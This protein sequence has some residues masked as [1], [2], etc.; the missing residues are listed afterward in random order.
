M[1]TDKDCNCPEN[2]DNIQVNEVESIES[3][4][5]ALD[6]NLEVVGEDFD[7]PME[8]PPFQDEFQ[9]NSEAF[10]AGV[11]HDTKKVTGLWSKDETRNS[12]AAING[13]GW[14]KLNNTNNSSCVALTILSAHAKQY[15]KNVKLNIDNNQIKEMY[16]W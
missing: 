2:I 4:P 6:E 16:V 5:N 13:L 1:K 7:R 3:Q 10:G 15:N 12:W 14:K 11:W 8:T 9:E